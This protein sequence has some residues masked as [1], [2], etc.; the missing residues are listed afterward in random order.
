MR[1][2]KEQKKKEAEQEKGERRGRKRKTWQILIALCGSWNSEFTFSCATGNQ[3]QSHL[4]SLELCSF[5]PFHLF[6]NKYAIGPSQTQIILWEV[7]SFLWYTLCCC[8][9]MEKLERDC[10]GTQQE[11]WPSV[12]RETALASL[13]SWPRNS[14]PV[15]DK[16]G[17]NSNEPRLVCEPH[18]PPPNAVGIILGKLTLIP[19]PIRWY[20]MK[21]RLDLVNCYFSRWI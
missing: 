2:G 6:L 18:S 17:G 14:G 13:V 4:P 19:P 20:G 8:Q 15:N 10:L 5:S 16:R 12:Q 11:V 9:W 21:W 3:P 1:V 7:L